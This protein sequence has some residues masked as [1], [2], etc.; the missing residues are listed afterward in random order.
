MAKK[1]SV[2]PI[3][4][5][6]DFN[7]FKESKKQLLASEMSLLRM[8]QKIKNYKALRKKEIK[9]RENIKDKINEIKG[10]EKD[11]KKHLPEVELPEIKDVKDIDEMVE[12]KE[13]RGKLETELQEIQKRL[14]KLS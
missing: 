8:V 10:Y 6:F 12:E 2:E 5:R 14:K 1:T 13:K 4:I 11:F 7:E 9:L 3:H